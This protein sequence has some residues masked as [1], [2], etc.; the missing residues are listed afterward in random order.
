[1]PRATGSWGPPGLRTSTAA[2]RG[3]VGGGWS[4][5]VGALDERP[6][7]LSNDPAAFAGSAAYSGLGDASW[8]GSRGETPA[9]EVVCCV[10]SV[11]P[12]DRFDRLDPVDRQCR[13]DPVDRQCCVVRVD[14]VHRLGDERVVIPVA[15]VAAVGDV[16][17]ECL[18]DPLDAVEVV[19]P[20]LPTPRPLNWLRARG[21]AHALLRTR[22]QLTV[23][24]CTSY[25]SCA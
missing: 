5:V 24:R 19:V 4:D 20:W 16:L 14:R 23:R 2:L 17:P 8:E 21:V 1:M 9:F 25:R 10:A 13:L 12:V 7:Q 6:P 22:S 3:V 18:L 15:S 11:H